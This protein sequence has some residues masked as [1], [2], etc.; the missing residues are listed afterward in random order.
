MKKVRFGVKNK[1]KETNEKL[2]RYILGWRNTKIKISF[3]Q[4]EAKPSQEIIFSSKSKK[5]IQLPLIFNNNNV[6]ETSRQKLV[7]DVLGFKLTF[8]DRLNNAL[9]QQTGVILFHL[10]SFSCCVWCYLFFKSIKFILIIC[11]YFS[12]YIFNFTNLV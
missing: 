2:L 12:F 4:D 8:E 6:S 3:N 9:L 5:P 1:K 10:V 7:G 11:S